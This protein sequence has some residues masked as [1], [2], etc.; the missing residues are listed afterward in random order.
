MSL[1]HHKISASMLR[2]INGTPPKM[3]LSL[4]AGQKHWRNQQHALGVFRSHIDTCQRL[5][6]E[7]IYIHRQVLLPISCTVTL[8]EVLKIGAHLSKKLPPLQRQDMV[9]R[10]NTPDYDYICN[11]Q[12]SITL[13][14][15]QLP[16]IFASTAIHQ[17]TM[18]AR[19]RY[20]KVHVL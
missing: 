7:A 5:Y 17:S 11:S 12:A 13:Q 19:R 16:H 4:H 14:I 20:F 10:S 3:P 9:S 15:Y 8:I 6:L 1:T 18:Q 2:V